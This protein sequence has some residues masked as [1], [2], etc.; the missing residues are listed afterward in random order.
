MSPATLLGRTPRIEQPNSAATQ[1]AAPGGNT[2]SAWTEFIAST[3][4]DARWLDLTLRS[5]LATNDYL[6]DVGVGAAGS[7]VPII[8]NVH[9]G[10]MLNLQQ[11]YRFPA[12]IP[13]GSRVSAR[14]RGTAAADLT[15]H[16]ALHKLGPLVGNQSFGR[17]RA[18]GITLASHRGTQVDPGGTV[19]TYGSWTRM[20]AAELTPFDV[21]LLW[22]T[23]GYQGN[24]SIAGANFLYE[25]AATPDAAATIDS[26]LIVE[27]LQ[28]RTQGTTN[29]MISPAHYGPFEVEVPKGYRIYV[30][31][32]SSINTSPSRLMSAVVHVAG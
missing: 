31:A 15:T 18:M 28:M 22:L 14:A 23:L 9:L 4:A 32:M 26:G 25:V 29:T 17:V 6:C 20:G 16:I 3:A 7:E 5:N 12:L 19:N 30:R 21:R 13:K 27:G 2:W 8:E 1:L 10:N 24:T 11:H